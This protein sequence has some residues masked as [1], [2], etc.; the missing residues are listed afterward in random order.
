[1]A[2]RTDLEAV[3]EIER[4]TPCPAEMAGVLGEAGMAVSDV[5]KD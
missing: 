5:N 1:M 4:S 3:D 2:L